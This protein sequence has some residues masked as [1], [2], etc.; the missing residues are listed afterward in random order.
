MILGFI[1]S[2]ITCPY[3]RKIRV[4]SYVLKALNDSCKFTDS[5]PKK[6]LIY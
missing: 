1:L 6:P 5:T 3:L 4:V 2:D